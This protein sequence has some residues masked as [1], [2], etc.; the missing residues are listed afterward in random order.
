ML[1]V[2][3]G[4]AGFVESSIDAS[5]ND[6]SGND[7]T[8]VSDWDGYVQPYGSC[9]D[10][11]VED[12]G[13]GACVG[14]SVDPHNCG[15]CNHDCDG[16]DCADGSCVPLAPDVLASGQH[17]PMAIVADD[18]SV[19]WT[20]L[21][22]ASGGGKVA[23]LY[24]GGQLMKCAVGGC[25]NAPTVLGEALGAAPNS[26]L[27]RL[28]LAIDDANV[29]WLGTSPCGGDG[30]VACAKTGCGQAPT[31]LAGQGAASIALTPST[32][33]WSSGSGISAC[34]KAGCNLIGASLYGP[35][36][37]S[38][39][40]T[41]DQSHVYWTDGWTLVSGCEIASCVSTV[42]SV[43]TPILADQI[44]SDSDNIYWTTINGDQGNVYECAKADCKDTVTV[45]AANRPSPLGIAV[46]ATHVYW[47]EFDFLPGDNPAYQIA[48]CAITGCGGT[49]TVIAQNPGFAQGIAVD[50]TRVYW[51][52]WSVSALG[53]IRMLMK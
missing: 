2:S 18:T 9:L 12:G 42:Q 10:A 46:D 17:A 50:S 34:A 19:Y 20:N 30:I 23:T 41:A 31:L 32:V 6:A 3:C 35:D 21:G 14:S 33:V 15:A 7:G 5:G 8:V 36:A 26:E 53:R 25:A 44:T 24:S 51:A 1:A 38:W 11:A 47:T 39:G 52:E 13:D 29:Y 49:A 27:A 43:T 28:P 22:T 40:V 16:G 48:T 4:T 45:L 37:A